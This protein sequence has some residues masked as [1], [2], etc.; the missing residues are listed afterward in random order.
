MLTPR[1][2]VALTGLAVVTYPVWPAHQQ[3]WLLLAVCLSPLPALVTGL[4]RTT[5]GA[6]RVAW[7][8]LLAGTVVYD[9]G[10]AVWA[11]RLAEAGRAAADADSV[12]RLTM[13]T[14]GALML[15]ASLTVVLRRGR[16]DTGGIIDSVIAAI[17]LSGVLWSIV[18]F[19][20]MTADG[21]STDQQIIRFLNVFLLAGTLG[22]MLRVSLVPYRPSAPV[23]LLCASVAF[24]LAQSV[25]AVIGAGWQNIPYMA[26]FVAVGGA[27]LHPSMAQMTAPGPTPVDDLTTGRLV[28][29]GIM[30]AIAPAIGGVRAVLGL[31]SDGLLLAI[32]SVV[33]IPLV[34][35]R[36][37][38]LSRARRAAEAALHR[39]ATSDS[40]TGLP[41]RAAS[42]ERITRELAAGPEDLAVLFCDL[43]GFKPVNDRLGHAAGDALLIGVAEHLRARLRVEDLVGR[44]GGDEFVIVCRGPGAADAMVDRVR[45]LAARPFTIGGEQVRIGVS[46][47][48]A[49]AQPHDTTDAILTRADLAMYEAKKRK[50]VG[51]LSVAS[52]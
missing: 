3:G 51:A 19:P 47:G 23:L 43:D 7:W 27:A 35:A 26:A 49:D 37:A 10:N 39:L 14:G 1:L 21:M 31:P 28:F 48:V 6:A 12:V 2:Y 17:G 46:V 20:A 11:W 36:I 50:K 16:A 42:V 41:N 44:F 52:A 4:R 29:L 25:S 18:L 9:V 8:L 13:I 22:G 30:L 40:L 45:T 33:M 24:A 15:A 32:S 38:R 5:P 34:M